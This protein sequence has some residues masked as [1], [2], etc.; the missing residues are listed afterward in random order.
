MALLHQAALCSPSSTAARSH[1]SRTAVC[2]S[3]AAQKAGRC[4]RRIGGSSRRMESFEVSLQGGCRCSRSSSRPFQ[5]LQS[6]PAIADPRCLP[7]WLPR[8]P[9]RLR[10]PRC[11]DAAVSE[12]T[13]DYVFVERDDVVR[14]L[15]AFIAEYIGARRTAQM[16]CSTRRWPAGAVQTLPVAGA[17]PAVCTAALLRAGA[18]AAPP[19]HV[20]ARRHPA[21]CPRVP[22]SLPPRVGSMQLQRLNS[23]S[24]GCWCALGDAPRSLCAVAQSRCPRRGAWS[25]GSCSRRW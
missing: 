16:L 11:A 12:Q 5:C 14:A 13:G 24:P 20:L 3:P 4:C 8:D 1:S 6:E 18:P 10:R 23:A 2:G 22:A 15:S 17:L 19:L 9:V 7:A 21:R 25:R